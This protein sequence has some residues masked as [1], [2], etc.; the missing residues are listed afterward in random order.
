MHQQ[1]TQVKRIAA[2]S[3]EMAQSIQALVNWQQQYWVPQNRLNLVRYLKGVVD[4]TIAA[5][6]TLAVTLQDAGQ[7]VDSMALSSKEMTTVLEVIKSIAEQ[8]NLLALNAAI[9]GRT[10]RANKDGVLQ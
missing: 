4:Q 2:A 6:D 7:K 5:I 10:G 9:E 3:E 8:T 1:N